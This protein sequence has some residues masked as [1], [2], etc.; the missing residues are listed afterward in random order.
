MRAPRSPSSAFRRW[1]RD[2]RFRTTL[3]ALEAL[4]PIQLAE[5]GIARGDISRLAY[6]ASHRMADPGFV[7]A[8]L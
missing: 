8:P 1:R 3:R 2:R 5:H 7:R 6:L 4:S